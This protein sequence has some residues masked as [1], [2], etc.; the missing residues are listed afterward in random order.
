MGW[1]KGNTLLNYSGIKS[2]LISCI[3]DKSESK[4]GKF[5]PGS[6]IPIVSPEKFLNID[7]KHI[8]IFPWN[9]INEHKPKLNKYNLYTSIPSF[10]KVHSLE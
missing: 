4:Q 6:K 7:S 10:R 8:I 9:L 1:R 5:S 3:A 2:D